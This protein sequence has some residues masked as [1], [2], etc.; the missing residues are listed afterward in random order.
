ME[1]QQILIVGDSFF[2]PNE[3]SWAW[4]N[5]LK[6]HYTVTNCATSGIGQYKI[7]KQLLSQKLDEFD[8]V[9]VG[10]T[11][12]TRVHTERNP[13]YRI[14][15]PSH[16]QCDLLYEDI[17]SKPSSKEKSHALWYFENILDV[18][19][20]DFIHK[21]I[22][23][24]TFNIMKHY[25]HTMVTFFDKDYSC[26]NLN[27]IWRHNTGNVNHLSKQGHHLVYQYIHNIFG[28]I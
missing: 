1:K 2:A 20:Y 16:S 13:F 8:H 3:F 19:Y 10:I 4:H 12:S 26:S 11:S 7:L 17:K 9:I 23:D 6:E 27:H 25:D 18:D 21:L 22:I 24:H 14:D 28:Q 5:Q 15:H